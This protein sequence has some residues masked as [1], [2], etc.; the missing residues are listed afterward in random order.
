[1]RTLPASALNCARRLA[2]CGASDSY[3]C[4]APRQAASGNTHARRTAIA[5]RRAATTWDIRRTSAS[6]GSAESCRRSRCRSIRRSRAYWRRRRTWTR[7]L[8]YAK[9]EIARLTWLRLPRRAAPHS[10][11]GAAVVLQI[12]IDAVQAVT[13]PR[14][15]VDERSAGE[16]IERDGWK[17]RRHQRGKR[18]GRTARIGAMAFDRSCRDRD[19]ARRQLQCREPDAEPRVGKAG[20]GRLTRDQAEARRAEA[21]GVAALGSDAGHELFR[22]RRRGK[23]LR[24]V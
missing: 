16:R 24:F 1:M 8:W 2:T 5:R 18:R 20:W 19:P 14:H 10:V 11:D 6:T 3:G 12:L 4:T 15:C 7:T 21:V 17:I 23:R 13:G 9:P 22:P